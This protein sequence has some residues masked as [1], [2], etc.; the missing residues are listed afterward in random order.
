MA[1]YNSS[2][3][4][5]TTRRAA[6]TFPWFMSTKPIH[7]HPQPRIAFS[8]CSYSLVDGC[9]LV[10]SWGWSRKSRMREHAFR[11]KSRDQ[12]QAQAGYQFE[13]STHSLRLLLMRCKMCHPMTDTGQ[14]F[15]PINPLQS[16]NIVI[17]ERRDMI[18]GALDSGIIN[19]THDVL[20]FRSVELF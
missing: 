14:S 6:T 19:C 20:S 17:C 13:V 2:C 8:W 11:W 1:I 12:V 16:I 9:C 18:V 15:A 3:P 4:Y 10:Y 5:Y 7:L